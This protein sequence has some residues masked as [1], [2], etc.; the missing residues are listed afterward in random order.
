[1]SSEHGVL[2]VQKIDASKETVER[3]AAAPLSDK[4]REIISA[5]K[6]TALQELLEPDTRRAMYAQYWNITM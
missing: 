4:L 1:M 2:A 3:A 6:I 5:S